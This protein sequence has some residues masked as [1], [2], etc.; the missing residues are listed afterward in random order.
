MTQAKSFYHNLDLNK[1]HQIINVRKHNITTVDRIALGGTLNNDHKGLTVFDTDL[2][3]TFDWSGT[4]WGAVGVGFEAAQVKYV[5][6]NGSDANSGKDIQLPKRTISD[7]ISVMVNGDVL[8]INRGV[9]IGNVTISTQ[10]L[11][12]TGDNVTSR[13]DS[14]PTIIGDVTTGPGTRL[15]DVKISGK[16]TV[17]ATLVSTYLSSLQA[18]TL[19]IT[20]DESVEISDVKAGSTT[21]NGSSARFIYGSTFE[22]LNVGNTGLTRLQDCITGDVNVTAGVFIARNLDVVSP[23]ILTIGAGVIYSLPS[24]TG[25]VS[26]HPDAV[27]LETAML[28]DGSTAVQADAAVTSTFMKLAML[29][30]AENLNPTKAVTFN[31]TTKKLEI[32]D[33]PKQEPIY[34]GGGILAAIAC[35][36]SPVL[37]PTGNKQDIQTV[38]T[39]GDHDSISAA[40]AS[41]DVV[42]GTILKLISDLVISATVNVTKAVVIDLGVFR[43]DTATTGPVVMFNMTAPLAVVKNGTV[44]HLKS[45]NTSVESIFNLASTDPAKPVFVVDCKINAMEFG[46]TARGNYIVDGNTFGYIGA[47]ATNSHRYIELY[48]NSGESKISNNKFTPITATSPRYTSFILMT[49]TTGSVYGGKLYVNNNIQTG[50][51]LRQFFLHDSGDAGSMELYIGNNEFDD[52]NGGIGILSPALYNSYS[53]IGIFNNKQGSSATGN[54][55]GV[56]FIDGTGA[57]SDTVELTYDGNTTTASALR[58]DYVSLDTNSQNLIAVKN[59]VTFTAKKEAPVVGDKTLEALGQ[60]L[61]DIKGK[62]FYI[63]DAFGE[64]LEGNGVEGDPFVLPPIVSVTNTTSLVPSTVKYVEVDVGGVTQLEAQFLPAQADIPENTAHVMMLSDGTY[65]NSGKVT[66]PDHGLDTKVWYFLSQNVAGSYITPGPETGIIQKLFF[67]EDENTIHVNVIGATA[68]ND[69]T[70][71][72]FIASGEIPNATVVV[73]RE[74]GKVEAPSQS[75]AG[76]KVSSKTAFNGAAVSNTSVVYNPLLG[77]IVVA[78][79]DTGNS[80]HGT[81]IT[82]T[83]SDTGVTFD[84]KVVFNSAAT[85]DISAMYDPLSNNVLIAFVDEGNS[86]H[87][88]AIVAQMTDTDISFG[89]KVVF[90]SG[91]TASTKVTYDS[92]SN[93]VVVAYSDVSNSNF[94]T[95]SVGTITNSTIIFGAKVVFLNAQPASLN[96]GF[97]A[98]FDNNNNKVIVAY[99]DPSTGFGNIVLGTVT[100]DTIIF[101]TP[102]AFSSVSTEGISAVYHPPSGKIVITYRDTTNSKGLATLGSIAAGIITFTNSTQFSGTDVKNTSIVADYSSG[103]VVITFT[104][105]SA[106]NHGSVIIG[107]INNSVITFGDE[108]VFNTTATDNITT[109]FA[110]NSAR[111][112]AIYKDTD[113]SNFGGANVLFDDPGFSNIDNWLG[114]TRSAVE[115]GELVAVTLDG[116]TAVNLEGL[117][118]GSHYYLSE[119]GVL[120]TNSNSRYIGRALAPNKLRIIGSG[121]RIIPSFF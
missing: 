46:V 61:Q 112:I 110:A 71:E 72:T 115:D 33:F 10:N 111:V 108:T 88:S 21:I 53:K 104:D 92:S 101:N 54:F 94:G 97:S 36:G 93:K 119:T 120:T 114:I 85:K 4:A 42:D 6:P 26:I 116:E 63:A 51:G 74:D 105:V 98:V 2:L 81:I 80:N 13:S 60:L 43:I 28:S 69:Y 32:S 107:S 24:V 113:S 67:V 31:Q 78:Y 62:Q 50:S 12:I 23:S 82:G 27:S 91:A 77:K 73:L 102:V 103:K 83:V 22:T 7:A 39:G 18:G 89:T 59:T 40:L 58:A 68:G 48:G 15:N 38:G 30:P 99:R 100:A 35:I 49:T 45:T 118:P 8:K 25:I 37:V 55:K 121:V 76:I 57:L 14:F 109:A 19:E 29:T 84:S 56:F 90:N 17:D 5:D 52:L 65:I 1:A 95:V 34:I 16:L 47:S 87:G 11:V 9:Y 20:G 96:T 64:L 70:N 117:I 79:S 75:I 41:P 106:G 66:W 86:D 44:N 3:R